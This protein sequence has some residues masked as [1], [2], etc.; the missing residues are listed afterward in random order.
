[1]SGAD[2]VQLMQVNDNRGPSPGLWGPCRFTDVLTDPNQGFIAR[3][4]FTIFPTHAS[5]ASG[6][7]SG[8]LGSYLVYIYQGGAIADNGVGGVLKFSSD[9]DNE[10]A[11]LGTEVAPFEVRAG[12]K[13]WFEA[14]VKTSTITNDKHGIFVGLLEKAAVAAAVPIATTGALA[15]KSLIGFHRLE[16]DGDQFD[17]VYRKAGQAVQTVKADAVEIE[18]D[19]FYKLGFHFDGKE[20]TY[21]LNGRA[22]P[23]KVSAASIAAATFPREIGLGLVFAVMNATGT[24]PGDSSI[25]WIQAVQLLA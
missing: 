7:V 24:T 17:T 4:D 25:D 12:T 5:T 11:A 3:D 10:G 15:D 8:A 14:R 16:G 22:L 18:A 21:Y 20:L 23:D 6:A 1:M 9:G 2:K 19:T 13:L